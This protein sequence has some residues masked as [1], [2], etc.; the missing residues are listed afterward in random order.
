MS[1]S[2]ISSCASNL[3][4][5]TIALVTSTS[6]KSLFVLASLS[7]SLFRVP[8]AQMTILSGFLHT[9]L[10]EWVLLFDER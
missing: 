2:A 9:L 1:V 7:Q 10:V 6:S 5:E 4:K 3:R 8:L